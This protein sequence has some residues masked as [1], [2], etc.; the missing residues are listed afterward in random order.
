MDYFAS[1]RN[2]NP[3]HTVYVKTSILVSFDSPAKID[4]TDARASAK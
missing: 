4:I 2:S 3:V 1:F